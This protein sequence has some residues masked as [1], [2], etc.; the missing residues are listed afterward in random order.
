MAS[1]GVTAARIATKD[2]LWTLPYVLALTSAL[3]FFSAFYLTLGALPTYLKSNL[4]SNTG[5]IG[6]V[7]GLFG[8]TAILPRPTIGRIVNAGVT[9][10]PMLIAAGIFTLAN[11]LYVGATSI[12]LLIA[13]RLFHGLGMAGYTNAAPALVASITPTTRRGEAMA[14]WGVANTIALAGGP[15]LGLALASRWGY[16]ACFWVAATVGALGIL[17]TALLWPSQRMPGK[18]IL[19]PTGQLLESRV[20]KPAVACY[21]LML[22][23]GTIITFIIILA[24]E[25]K[26]AGA[27]FFFTI[28]ATGL[29]ATRSVAGRLSDRY[30]RWIV[31]FPG[32]A[33]MAAA[34][35]VASLV[36]SL[37]IFALAALLAG[38]G[39]GAAQP[40]LLALTVDLVPLD[41][42]GSAVA[43]YYVAHETGIATGS[44]ALGWVA[45]AITLGGM[46][47]LLG[48]VL[49]V[50]VAVLARWVTRG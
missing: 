40:A 10:P 47:A 1:A 18:F 36:H 19:P 16:P 28:Y 44:I 23:Y 4:G 9:L 48:A 33:S 41:R 31:A 14:Y 32:I 2:R 8:V 29:L 49:L 6:L 17:V 38:G 22:G 7:L 5:Q 25:R 3:F 37:P 39:F 15:A 24:D 11:V 30:G 20:L 13:F 50:A 27:G 21:L 35:L 42:R 12:P 43:T 45:E 26:I 34:L 46:F